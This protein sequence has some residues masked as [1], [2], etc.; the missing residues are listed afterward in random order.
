MKMERFGSPSTCSCRLPSPRCRAVI[1]LQV[2]GAFRP[3]GSTHT[4]LRGR[5]L[6]GSTAL[7]TRKRFLLH[8]MLL[9]LSG[10]AGSKLDISARYSP[11]NWERSPCPARQVRQ[12]K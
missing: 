10:Q 8:A 6:L 9:C 7:S 11:E 3:L 4:V 1:D 2:L 5:G 12:H